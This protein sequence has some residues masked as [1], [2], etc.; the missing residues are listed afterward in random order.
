SDP[1]EPLPP[2][3]SRLSTPAPPPQRVL[4]VE[5]PLPSLRPLAFRIFT[6]K[7]GLTL[8]SEA[9]QLLCQFI[10]RKCGADWRDGAGEKMLDEIARGWK[11]AEGP[12]GVLVEGG[13][14]LKAVLKAVEVGGNGPSEVQRRMLEL[15]V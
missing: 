6:K 10:G 2:S 14:A 1:F 5:I 12:C 3:S 9:L 4:A 8:K 11:R 13:E 7:H 15:R